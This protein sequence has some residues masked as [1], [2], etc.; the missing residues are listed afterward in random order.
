MKY[1]SIIL[2]IKNSFYNNY[3]TN[4]LH[5]IFTINKVYLKL[6]KNLFNRNSNYLSNKDIFIDSF[7]FKNNKIDLNLHRKINYYSKKASIYRQLYIHSLLLKIQKIPNIYYYDDTKYKCNNYSTYDKY[8]DL[9]KDYKIKKIKNIKKIDKLLYN[10]LITVDF[11]NIDKKDSNITNDK[12]K[13]IDNITDT[14]LTNFFK[15]PDYYFNN[16]EPINSRIIDNTITILNSNMSMPNNLI[17]NNNSL[18]F[19]KSLYKEDISFNSYY[20]IL[21]SISSPKEF[22]EYY[23]NVYSY[24][25]DENMISVIHK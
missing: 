9:I 3:V 13:S 2:Y 7:N 6:C 24:L 15:Q 12:D 17:K 1:K 25:N 22:L 14:Y 5:D 8:V 16:I 10:Y 11:P 4:K 21:L 19:Y 20:K 18:F 23:F